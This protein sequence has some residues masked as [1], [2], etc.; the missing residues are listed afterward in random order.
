M[1]MNVDEKQDV[2]VLLKIVQ[3]EKQALK[4]L[5]NAQKKTNLALAFLWM[6]ENWLKEVTKEIVCFWS[7]TT[8]RATTTTTITGTTTL[9]LL[10][11]NQEKCIHDHKAAL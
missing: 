7:S 9:V 2:V 6:W 10:S 4:M 5:F 3:V 8:I 1:R 11:N